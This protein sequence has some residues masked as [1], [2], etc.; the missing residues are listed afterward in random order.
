MKRQIFTWAARLLVVALLALGGVRWGV[1]AY[2]QY[3]KPKKTTVFVPV[4]TVR[5][6][7]FTVSFHEIGT[8]IAEKSVF[9]SSRINGKLIT[10]VDDG[11]I[12]KEGDRIALLD[13]TDLEK[14]MRNNNLAYQNSLADIGRAQNELEIFKAANQTEVDQA[15]AELDFDKTELE[16]VKKQLE[17]KIRLSQDKLVP[18]SEVEDA[19][20]QVRIKELDVLKGEKN[21][22]LK[23]REI[24][25]TERQKAADVRNVEFKSNIARLN[26]EDTLGKSENTVILAPA[27]GLVVLSKTY[28]PDGR[29][30][31]Q[32]GDD[33]RPKQVICEIP[34]MKSMQVRVLVG[35]TDVSRVHNDMPVRIRLEADPAKLFHGKVVKISNLAS[36]GSAMDANYTPGKK[37]FEVTV[38]VR[39][40]DPKML[41]PGMTADVEFIKEELKTAVFVPLEAVTEKDG[42]TWVYVRKSGKYRKTQ[43]KTG[44]H[45]DNFVAVTKGLRPG[46]VVAL[47]NPSAVSGTEG[48]SASDEKKGDGKTGKPVPLIEEPAR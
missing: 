5:E 12:V 4:T 8:L 31:L 15:Q 20:L 36:E 16:R 32:P 40:T 35:E 39:E 24:M 6:G 41:K 10:L 18:K 21:L 37:I 23:K 33:V 44:L 25:A 29:R 3:F 28:S 13:G 34:D 17:K 11:G 30:R 27:P 22:V 48:S 9:V 14:E 1:P 42:K 43:I 7:G 38:A 19:E 26:Y 47:R 2:K 45:N 46:D